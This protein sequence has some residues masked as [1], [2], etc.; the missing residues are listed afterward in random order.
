MVFLASGKAA[1]SLLRI[2]LDKPALR[3]QVRGLTGRRGGDVFAEAIGKLIDSGN[4]VHVAALF[5]L[6]GFLFRN[7]LILRSLIIV[8]DIIYILYFY[9][10]PETPLWG[11]V[12]WSA[13]FC[14]VN[15]WM[16]GQILVD[17][18]TFDLKP[19]ER[20][21]FEIWG[22]FTP[23]QFRKLIRL[24]KLERTQLRKPISREGRPLDRLYFV[25]EGRITVEKRGKHAYADSKTFIGEDAFL[26]GGPTAASVILE[27]G[28]LYFVW[29]V[30]ALKRLLEADAAL[31]TAMIHVLNRV[32]VHKVMKASVLRDTVLPLRDEVA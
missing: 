29:N 4:I 13:L 1:A 20:R 21:L 27:P 14:V 17:K 3:N 9:F 5:Y 18:A 26:L 10:A 30:V 24:G 15:L 23:G 22:E 7:P 31:K 25:M 8:G 11:G 28:A 2:P 32:L 12:F 6:S 19:D 16:I